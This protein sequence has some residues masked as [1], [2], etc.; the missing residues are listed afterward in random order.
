[1][2][3]YTD[4]NQLSHILYIIYFGLPLHD[5]TEHLSSPLASA[6][7][8]QPFTTLIRLP[9]LIA[10]NFGPLVS[11]SVQF[12]TPR[13]TSVQPRFT[14]VLSATRLSNPHVLV[15]YQQVLCLKTCINLQISIHSRYISVLITLS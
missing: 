11:I 14:L 2:P 12:G 15:T 3:H 8:T 13:H 10:L 5:L 1:M 4:L 7:I 9:I 6:T